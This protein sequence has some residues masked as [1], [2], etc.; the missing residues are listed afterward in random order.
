L[1]IPYKIYSFK[2]YWKTIGLFKSVNFKIRRAS[3]KGKKFISTEKETL[4][5]T[6]RQ[7]KIVLWQIVKAFLSLVLLFLIEYFSTKL[8]FNY[9]DYIPKWIISFHK[10]IPKTIYP[11]NKDA[12]LY[13][14]SVIASVTGVILAL[15]YPV[16]A[17]I[18]STA[19]A[20]VNA[21]IRNLLFY[22]KETQN[23]LKRLT[24]LTAFSIAL[25]LFLSLD[26]KPRTLILSFITLYS[27]ITLFGI[28]KIGLGVYEFLDPSMLSRIVFDK[29]S[30]NINDVTTK[31]ENFDERNFQSYYH[32]LATGQIENLSTIT[33]LSIDVNDVNE[34]SLQ[35]SVSITYLI[36]QNYL[37]SKSKIPEKSL[38]F[39][40][41]FEHSSYFTSDTTHR[42]LSNNTNTFIQPNVIQDYFW[43]EDKILQNIANISNTL[44]S[45]G[46]ITIFNETSKNS[47]NV[48][49][50]L[51]YSLD[52]RTGKNLLERM[53]NNTSLIIKN[54]KQQTNNYEDIKAELTSIELYS[55]N[56]LSFQ[57]YIL[58][59]ITLFDSIKLG[60]E[61]DKINWLDNQSIYEIDI[62]PE[63][64]DTL[65]GL[66]KNLRNEKLIEE[67]IITPDWYIKQKISAKYIN[68]ISKKLD[69]TIELF[70]KQI[71]SLV[72][73]NQPLLTSFLIQKGLEIINKL[74]YRFLKLKK[75]VSD[76]SKFE[77]VEKEF[78]WLKP[79]FEKI[80]KQLKNYENQCI[81]ILSKNIVETSNVIWN[82]QFPDIFGQSYS[83]ISNYINKSF[84][85]NNEELINQ[86]FPPFLESALNAFN[87]LNKRYKDYYRPERISYQVLLDAMEISSYSYIYSKLYKKDTYWIKNKEAWDTYF[88]PTKE[89]IEL[90][91]NL[92]KYYKT[93]LFGVGINHDDKNQRTLT[94]KKIVKETKIDINKINDCFVE[95]FLE[96][97]GLFSSSDVTEVFIEKYLF[98]LEESVEAKKLI[99]RDVQKRCIR[100]E[101]LKKG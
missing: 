66:S 61:I 9:I 12:V 51:G 55:G 15:F 77:K 41:I 1:K 36:L 71:L 14:V 31:G 23:F 46:H 25:L 28:L 19:Y 85:E 27:L 84:E 80:D 3:F 32:N 18:A 24:F 94:L 45:N 95:T 96:R 65:N 82:N 83:M 60:K 91:V 4:S 29:L 92:Y 78:E 26:Y 76:I 44:I 43:F 69:D 35:K 89:N 62:I 34:S 17:T 99:K 33:R 93:E 10:T 22:D 7:F 79:D 56:F 38:W 13:L 68:I 21:N 86:V 11:T 6:Y 39:P 58:E 63:L 5:N 16:L 97:D 53:L 40:K 73:D 50:Y 42:S 87:Q 57:I 49:S 88:T 59:R 67:V 47:I 52:L 101:N 81:L 37:K 48:L 20:K 2:Q 74:N 30:Q 54:A 75:S 72:E 70:D 100:K 90:L 64:Y 98:K 8:W